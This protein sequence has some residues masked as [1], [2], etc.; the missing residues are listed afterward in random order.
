[1]EVRL[2]E[3]DTGHRLAAA[4]RPASLDDI[5][6]WRQWQKQIPSNAENGHWDW[7]ALVRLPVRYPDSLACFALL[8]EG[9]LHG[10][11]LLELEH[12]NDVGEHDI[13]VLRLATA[14]W[15]RGPQG[16][17]TGVGTGLIHKA[18]VPSFERGHGGRI[19]LEALP[20]AEAFYRRIG[21]AELPTLDPAEGLAQFKFSAEEAARFLKRSEK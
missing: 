10:L 3:R 5:H 6:L 16:R 11:M 8:A 4:I 7:A 9:R 18:I 19:W 2:T 13:H 15:N 1:M 12:K 14:P 20:G 17:L 21:M